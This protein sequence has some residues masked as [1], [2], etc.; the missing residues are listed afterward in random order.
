MILHYT[1]KVYKMQGACLTN[2]FDIWYNISEYIVWKVKR[3]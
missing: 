3:G 2:S 1:R